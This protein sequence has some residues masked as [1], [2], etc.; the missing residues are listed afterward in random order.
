[1]DD[2]RRKNRDTWYPAARGNF[3]LAPADAYGWYGVL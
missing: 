1:M 3:V 2:H